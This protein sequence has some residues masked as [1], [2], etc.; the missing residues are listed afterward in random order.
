MFK[1]SN[2]GNKEQTSKALIKSKQSWF[3]KIPYLFTKPSLSEEELELLEEILLSSDAGYETTINI[4]EQVRNRLSQASTSDSHNSITILKDILIET[5]NY[6]PNDNYSKR[7]AKPYVI[8]VVGINGVGKTTSIAKLASL[9]TQQGKTVLLS[10]G[11]TFRAAA[12]EQLT[13][14]AE[15]LKVD[16]VKQPQGSDP[17][18]VVYDSYQA[19]VSRSIDVLLIDTAGRMN[20]K[21]NLM[22]ELAKIKRILSQHDSE[23]PHEVI[24]VLDATTGLNGLEQAKAF[25]ESTQT[26][27]I[28]LTKLDGTS[29]GGVV[30]PITSELG[31]PIIFIGTGETERDIAYFD[32][33]DFVEAIL[34]I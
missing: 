25:T 33:E 31:I 7:E 19:A 32:P 10:A 20:N 30:F 1:K 4:I 8:L 18:A 12:S 14:W 28:F 2:N 27:G 15:K 23:A 16:I 29:K 3:S 21:S 9:F 26:S 5:L 22:D 11:D 6:D 24:L 34:D 13:Y 17:G